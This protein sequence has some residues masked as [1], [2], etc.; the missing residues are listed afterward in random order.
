MMRI[1]QIT[2]EFS[3]IAKAGGLGE[4]V[5]G[6]S[7]ELTAVGQTVEIFLPKYDFLDL[8]KIQKLKMDVPDFKIPIHEHLYANAMWSAEC[9]DC[10]LHLLETR[11]PAGYLQR[12]KIYGY[13]DDVPRFL[14][15]SLAMLEYLKL[16][17]KPIDVLH[18]HDW[19]FALVAILAR[20][21]FKLPISTIV[22]TI[23]SAEY[24]GRCATWDFDAIGFKGADYLFKNKLQDDDPAYPETLNLLKGAI[25]YADAITTV[26][27]SYAQEI[28]TK[29][30][31]FHLGTTLRKNKKKLTPILN[32]ID[33][34]FWDPSKDFYIT[35]HYDAESS[36]KTIKQAKQASKN[37]LAAQFSL[38]GNLPWVG[39]ITR[40]VPQKGPKLIEEA[41][42][43][44]IRLGGTFILLGSSPMTEIQEHFEQLKIEYADHPQ[45]LLYL[46]YNESLAH[47]IYAALDFLIVPSLF[48]PCGLTQLIAMRYGTVPIVRS[49]GGLKDTVF[50][51]NDFRVP[52]QQRN[53]F[54]FSEASSDS[55]KS[56]FQKA[57]A[58]FHKEKPLF[59]SL[60][61][62]DMNVNSSWKTPAKE[63]L[64]LYTTARDSF[65]LKT[66]KIKLPMPF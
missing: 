59:D 46:D 20:D 1:V 39:A 10:Q 40:L 5:L 42:K 61:R 9:E 27:P 66:S 49:T 51:C 65:Q 62:H 32:G 24:Q 19:H 60:I 63:Y 45:V 55:L 52:I 15:F 28:L 11:H 57:F 38:K 44:T 64:R 36:L 50:D 31:E 48:E 54:V 6:L 14:Y 3:P 16:Q 4:M 34:K 30:T 8:S 35:A 13:E 2:A 56:V 37:L 18:L 33:Q 58:I 21:H 41:L 7:R 29:Q 17:N 22:L 26:S 25:I 47:Q 43:E 23:H 12:N 53:G